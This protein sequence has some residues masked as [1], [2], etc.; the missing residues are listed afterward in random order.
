MVSGCV[1]HPPGATTGKGRHLGGAALA[2]GRGLFWLDRYLAG[3]SRPRIWVAGFRS[4]GPGG[5]QH[6][7]PVWSAPRLGRAEEKPP[8][9]TLV[10]RGSF[11]T[12]LCGRDDKQFT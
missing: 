4:L 7:R 5:A 8:F 9:F 2:A 11:L 12:A 1:S 10:L 6:A 3:V